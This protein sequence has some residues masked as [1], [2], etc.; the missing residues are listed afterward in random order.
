MGGGVSPADYLTSNFDQGFPGG[1]VV[2]SPPAKAGITVSTPGWGRSAG[3]GNGNPLQ[4]SCLEHSMDRRAW[5][6]KVHRVTKSQTI[7]KRLSMHAHLHMNISRLLVFR[8]LITFFA[9]TIKGQ[10]ICWS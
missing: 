6:A 7:L 9:I 10:Y 3:E 1:S 4:Y 5:R 8:K 2:K